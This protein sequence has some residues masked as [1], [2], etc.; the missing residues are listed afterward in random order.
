M[1]TPVDL[2]FLGWV[3]GVATAIAM[4]AIFEWQERRKQRKQ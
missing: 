1:I 2:V 4:M 3:F